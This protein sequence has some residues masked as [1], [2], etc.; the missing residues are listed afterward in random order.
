MQEAW[1]LA[2]DSLRTTLCVR[3]RSVVV[4]CGCIFLASRRLGIAMPEN[5]PWWT[6]FGVEMSDMDIVCREILRLYTLPK[7]R[8]VSVNRDP[9]RS[10]AP[11]DSSTLDDA[12]KP[13]AKPAGTDVNG[14]ELPGAPPVLS[15][16]DRKSVV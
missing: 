14:T 2:N 15:A 12:S 8:Y 11:A 5:P 9:P 1:N 4:A 3:V 10:K 7:A 13:A 6:L 16:I